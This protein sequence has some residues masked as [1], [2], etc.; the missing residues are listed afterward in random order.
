MP[1]FWHEQHSA[2]WQTVLGLAVWLNVAAII[3]EE[4]ENN[5][6]IQINNKN[7]QDGLTWKARKLRWFIFNII[8]SS[9]DSPNRPLP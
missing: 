4:K 2:S 5:E 3:Q 1:W 7:L 8:L 9:L 6:A